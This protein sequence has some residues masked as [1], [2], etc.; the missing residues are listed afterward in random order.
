MGG[1]WTDRAGRGGD[2]FGNGNKERRESEMEFIWISELG[3]AILAP[4]RHLRL[5]LCSVSPILVELSLA[6]AQCHPIHPPFPS[7]P[8]PA[9]APP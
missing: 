6:L 3:G 8:R 5:A 4:S 7:F 2:V 1:W 9:N